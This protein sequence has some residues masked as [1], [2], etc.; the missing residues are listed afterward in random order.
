MNS[1]KK[2]L[3]MDERRCLSTSSARKGLHALPGVRGDVSQRE[4]GSVALAELW[5][6][7][8][9]LIVEYSGVKCMILRKYITLSDI[10]YA[11]R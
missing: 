11:E 4:G 1:V 6:A 5:G 9:M 2:V 10:Y 3:E 7:G 8:I